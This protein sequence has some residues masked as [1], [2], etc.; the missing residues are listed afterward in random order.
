MDSFDGELFDPKTDFDQWSNIRPHRHQ[1]AASCFPTMRPNDSIP[2]SVIQNWHRERVDF[3]RRHGIHV[4]RDWKA[5]Y[6]ELAPD[7]QRQLGK[8]C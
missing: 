8:Y 4:D 7:E 2:K 6:K 1:P 3:L 5:G